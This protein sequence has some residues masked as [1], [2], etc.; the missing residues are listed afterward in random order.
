MNIFILTHITYLLTL[1]LFEMKQKPTRELMADI[2]NSAMPKV[3]IKLMPLR[4]LF[5]LN[6]SFHQTGT[7]SAMLCF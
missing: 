4:I 3:I 1:K 5:L 6:L 7:A 2:N